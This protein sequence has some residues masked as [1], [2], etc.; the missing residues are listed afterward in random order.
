MSGTRELFIDEAGDLTLFDRRGRLLVGT[1]GCSSTFIVGVARVEDPSGLA[2]R[3]RAWRE[4]VLADPRFAHYQ[5]LRPERMRTATLFHAKDD[6]AP[7]RRLLFERPRQ[8]RSRSSPLSVA[9]TAWPRGLE[10]S[11]RFGGGRIP[12][13]TIL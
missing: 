6:P 5:S 9:S 4:E 2:D 7:V 3:L 13:T 1:P 8:N 11:N 12:S 10:R